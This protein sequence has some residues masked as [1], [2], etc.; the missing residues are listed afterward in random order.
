MFFQK[1]WAVEKDVLCD[2]LNIIPHRAVEQVF[3]LQVMQ[4]ELEAGG[5]AKSALGNSRLHYILA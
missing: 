4:A 3:V 2:F 1:A 5:H